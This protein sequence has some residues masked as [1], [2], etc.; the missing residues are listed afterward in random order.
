MHLSG[1]P[2]LRSGGKS[3]SCG[4]PPDSAGSGGGFSV[5]LR[6]GDQLAAH[7]SLML[8]RYTAHPTARLVTVSQSRSDEGKPIPSYSQRKWQKMNA[9]I[10]LFFL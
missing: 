6:P 2:L 5:I 8:Q 7:D 10:F 1:S 3:D 9:N 4:S